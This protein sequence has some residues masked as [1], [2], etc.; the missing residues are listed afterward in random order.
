VPEAV[1][2]KELATWPLIAVARGTATERGYGD[3]ILDM[4]EDEN[5]KPNIAK[6]A[7]DMHT[8]ACLVAAGM[9]VAVVP[10]IMQLM[11]PLGVAYRP[12]NAQTPGVSLS[13]AWHKDR[14]PA[15]LGP[16]RE[17]ARANAAK[18]I[19][20]HPQLFLDTSRLQVAEQET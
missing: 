5:C 12:L 7:H 17:A 4:F 6:E 11:Q 13:L 16:W 14:V 10:A 18:L 3:R 8:S 9:G 1:E 19:A 15:L 2:L 20:K